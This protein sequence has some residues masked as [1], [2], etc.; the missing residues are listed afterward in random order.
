[1]TIVLIYLMICAEVGFVCLLV[2]LLLRLYICLY[3]CVKLV[4]IP[5]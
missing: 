3:V 5:T 4:F 1:M 2:I